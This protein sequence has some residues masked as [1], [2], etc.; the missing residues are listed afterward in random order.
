MNPTA[1]APH[2]PERTHTFDNPRPL[3]E[4]VPCLLSAL[5]AAMPYFLEAFLACLSDGG[6]TEDYQPGSRKRC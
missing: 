6:S 5:V 2:D 1:N 3:G 4:F